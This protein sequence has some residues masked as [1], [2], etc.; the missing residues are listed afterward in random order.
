MRRNT[1]RAVSFF[2]LLTATPAAISPSSAQG[3]IKRQETIEYRI[4]C[5]GK[6]LFKRC[7]N[8]QRRCVAYQSSEG[9]P[10]TNKTCTDWRNSF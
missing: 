5:T 8:Q 1:L 7:A 3:T 4:H 6:G 10:A 9:G 2:L